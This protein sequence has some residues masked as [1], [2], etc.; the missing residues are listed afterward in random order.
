MQESAALLAV[1]LELL[2][3]DARRILVVSPRSDVDTAPLTERLAGAASEGTSPGRKRLELE[4]GRG[5]LD[6]PETVARI[7]EFDGLVL[8]LRRGKTP[9]ADLE[10]CRRLLDAAGARLISA[11]LLK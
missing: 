2:A 3:G 6:D 5:I 10:E 7:D 11:V 4:A 1:R 8:A 9:R